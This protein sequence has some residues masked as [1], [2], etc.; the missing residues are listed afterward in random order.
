MNGIFA[1]HDA[2][3]GQLDAF[4]AT[5]AC[6]SMYLRSALRRGGDLAQFA[7][8]REGGAIVAAAMQAASGMI[9]LQAPAGAGALTTT[10]L[11]STG[12]RLAGFLGPISQVQAARH[13]MGLDA[14]LFEKDTHEDLFALALGQLRAPVALSENELTC[15]I[16]VATDFAL[17]VEWRAAFRRQALNEGAGAQLDKTSRA[18]IAALL[19]AGS[20]FVL[21][22]D[23]PLAC[24][25][26][27][28][29]LPDMV[30]VGNVWTPPASR[31]NGYGRAVVAGALAIARDAGVASAV[32]STGRANLPALAAYRAI[33]FKLAGD[34]A[35]ATLSPDTALPSSVE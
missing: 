32:L 25:S 6:S 21:E 1:L 9:V 4:L 15:R 31:G 28:A 23:R 29:R 22:S 20:L 11:R 35:T 33:G 17:L 7:I 16:A 5:H 30:Q 14:V 3:V 10:I 18:D 27:N 34:Y 8:M 12:R 26:F 24:C 13:D 19:P 2:D